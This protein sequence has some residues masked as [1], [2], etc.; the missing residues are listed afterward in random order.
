MGHTFGGVVG[1][2]AL[3]L[4]TGPDS[5]ADAPV[6][7]Y[8]GVATPVAGAQ[9]KGKDLWLTLADLARA[10]KLEIKPQGV[11][12]E[13]TCV[14]V[15]QERKDRLI[16]E[17]SG[18]TWF[19]LSEFARWLKQPVAYDA[20]HQTWLFGP[21]PEEQNGHVASLLAPDFKLPD[22]QGKSHS[23]SDFRGK[24]VLLITWASW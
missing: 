13:K 22:L 19:N 24:K 20:K 14:P 16:T 10:T 23:L 5:R 17:R 9:A 3:I 6:V 1:L 2:L 11:C 12:T 8:G 18:T 4:A 15:P 21:W 7:I